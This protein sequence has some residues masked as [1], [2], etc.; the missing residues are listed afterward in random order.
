MPS[1]NFLPYPALAV[2]RSK[3]CIYQAKAQHGNPG[4]DVSKRPQTSAISFSLPQPKVDLPLARY[5]SFNYFSNATSK[6]GYR[7]DLEQVSN[8]RLPLWP[9]ESSDTSPKYGVKKG[10]QSDKRNKG[11][12]TN[13]ENPT[14]SK[15]WKERGAFLTNQSMGS[16]KERPRS[17]S[18]GTDKGSRERILNRPRTCKSDVIAGFHR[19]D[20][21]TSDKFKLDSSFSIYKEEE[22]E[23]DPDVVSPNHLIDVLESEN[24]TVPTT[25]CY[26]ALSDYSHVRATPIQLTLL[27]SEVIEPKNAKEEDKPVS[28]SSESIK[29]REEVSKRLQKNGKRPLQQ[30]SVTRP[31]VSLLET[32]R[33]KYAFNIHEENNGAKQPMKRNITISNIGEVTKLKVKHDNDSE[34]VKKSKSLQTRQSP[35]IFP[36][37]PPNTPI[38]R[39]TPRKPRL[40]LLHSSQDLTDTAVP[41]LI[42]IKSVPYK[43]KSTFYNG[44]HTDHQKQLNGSS[45]DVHFE[46][47]FNKDF[48]RRTMGHTS[49]LRSDA[50]NNTPQPSLFDP[51]DI[52]GNAF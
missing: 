4:G 12:L 41:M 1:D 51:S 11:L 43:P 34:F 14:D 48:L 24:V 23:P 49:Q 25:G 21:R 18:I 47:S 16:V 2:T 46:Q 44:I 8:H 30:P 13:A 36:V 7:K 29:E 19:M 33:D 9:K 5:S 37:S 17:H 42:E 3:G 32:L 27:N 35:G 52:C 15:F 39:Q 20:S 28:S 31:Y 26:S 50:P 38:Q 45:Y 22:E 10:R 6:P 40:Q